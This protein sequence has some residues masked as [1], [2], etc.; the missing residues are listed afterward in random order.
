MERYTVEEKVLAEHH[1]FYEQ[2]GVWYVVRDTKYDY[3]WLGAYATPVA[4]QE[5]IALKES[6]EL[7]EGRKE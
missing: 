7:A 5:A 6:K 4:A 1:P 2:D 3:L